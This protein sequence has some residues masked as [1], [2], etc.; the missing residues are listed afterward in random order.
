MTMKA[1]VHY[2]P[3]TGAG[4]AA[5]GL[6]EVPA[7]RLTAD[8]DAVT[9]GNCMS[10]LPWRNDMSQRLY[11]A[12]YERFYGPGGFLDRAGQTTPA[13]STTAVQARAALEKRMGD[14]AARVAG[15]GSQ[16]AGRDV[17]AQ[18]IREAVRTVM[19][20]AD[21]CIRLTA[22]DRADRDLEPP[23]TVT[24]DVS[25]AD[26]LHVL[27]QALEDYADKASV[28]ASREDASESFARWAA[29]ADRMKAQAEAAPG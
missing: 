26:T 6:P 8:L 23:R 16:G 25:G 4:K 15:F 11:R 3:E 1:A 22:A 19:L 18:V 13:S 21:A 9:C 29:I 7:E 5:C 20:G 27:T 10:G 17:I 24:F 14:E 12:D 28:M 2:T